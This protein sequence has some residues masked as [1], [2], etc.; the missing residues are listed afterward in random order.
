MKTAINKMIL[1]VFGLVVLLACHHWKIA[2]LALFVLGYFTW[3]MIRTQLELPRK[4]KREYDKKSNSFDDIPYSVIGAG[5]S[6]KP[7]DSG[8]LF[9]KE[10]GVFGSPQ[11]GALG[12]AGGDSFES[13]MALAISNSLEDMD[14][15]PSLSSAG[16]D[17]KTSLST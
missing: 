16:A 6:F 17:L 3:E 10:G 11:S 12:Q 1:A 13:D 2:P 15:Y 4:V 8:T 14:E 5:G 7:C 9:K